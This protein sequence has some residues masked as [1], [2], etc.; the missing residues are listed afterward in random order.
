MSS[1]A[2][3]GTGSGGGGEQPDV[4]SPRIVGKQTAPT[5]AVTKLVEVDLR[6]PTSIV[7]LYRGGSE[8][9]EKFGRQPYTDTKSCKIGKPIKYRFSNRWITLATSDS[10]NLRRKMQVDQ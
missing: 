5:V 7:V 6:D 2:A 8:V 9:N 1:G 10:G 4:A 3:V